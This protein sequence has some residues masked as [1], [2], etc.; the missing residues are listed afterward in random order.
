MSSPP[1]CLPCGD[2]WTRLLHFGHDY[3]WQV[4][5]IPLTEA[6]LRSGWVGLPW[7]GHPVLWVRPAND[8]VRLVPTALGTDHDENLRRN[9]Y[10][11]TKMVTGAR[12]KIGLRAMSKYTGIVAPSGAAT[13]SPQRKR[14]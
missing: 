8:P 14:S 10:L 2:L 1:G 12:P 5:T 4:R 7:V 11:A 3:G 6:V 13:S 9:I